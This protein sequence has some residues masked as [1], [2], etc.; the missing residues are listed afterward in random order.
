[1]QTSVSVRL[2]IFYVVLLFQKPDPRLIEKD[3]GN[4]IY[5][6]DIAADYS[7]ARDVRQFRK[8]AGNLLIPTPRQFF[9]VRLVGIFWPNLSIFL[10]SA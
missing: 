7:D 9:I 10:T 6:L 4:F 3:A 1:M 8:I 2:G 5:V